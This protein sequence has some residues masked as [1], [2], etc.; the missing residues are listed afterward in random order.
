MHLCKCQQKRFASVYTMYLSESF[1][2]AI[3]CSKNRI[4][5]RNQ[6]RFGIGADKYDEV[7]IRLPTIV[8]PH[9]HRQAPEKAF[10]SN[11]PRVDY[12]LWMRPW[13]QREIQW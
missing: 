9:S 2:F 6:P 7:S 5:K 3:Y 10:A 8:R 4:A 13:L 12:S 11:A 1:L